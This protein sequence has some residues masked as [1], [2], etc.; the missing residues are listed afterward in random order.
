MEDII[1]TIINT[2]LFKFQNNYEF[3]Q[4]CEENILSILKLQDPSV[5]MDEL[6]NNVGKSDY[7]ENR[8]TKTLEDQIKHSFV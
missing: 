1:E 4:E 6:A 7:D 3:L 2:L 8:A 5:M